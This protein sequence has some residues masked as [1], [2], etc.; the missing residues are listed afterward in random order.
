M[1]PFWDKWTN[2]QRDPTRYRVAL[3]LKMKSILKEVTLGNWEIIAGLRKAM[4][5]NRALFNSEAQEGVKNSA[6]ISDQGVFRLN[7]SIS[8]RKR[9]PARLH[10]RKE[11]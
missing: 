4:F 3:Q 7:M 1:R 6:Q 8:A 5:Q 11:R 2:R 9:P 10:C